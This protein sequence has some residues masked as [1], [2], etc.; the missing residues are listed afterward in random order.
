M[1]LY[2]PPALFALFVW[3]F[4]TGLIIYLDNLPRRTHRWS[5]AAAT[6]VLFGCLACL[7]ETSADPSLGGAY[8]GF[9]C[10]LLAWGWQEMSFFTGFVTGPVP[11]RCPPG[12]SGWDRF[13]RA[14]L[15]TAWHELAIALTAAVIVAATWGGA[16]QV[17][18]WTFMALWA[19]R[20]SAK[21]NVFLGVRNLSEEFVPEHL[22][23]IRSYLR[24]RPMNPLFPFAVTAGTLASA[25]MVNRAAAAPDAFA[26]T[27]DTFLAAMLILGVIEHWLLV[28]P[29]NF[30]A[31]W[32]WSLRAVKWR[33]RL[34]A[35]VLQ[36]LTPARACLPPRPAIPQHAGGD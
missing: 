29:V 24:Q 19:M 20:Q 2:G 3:W 23:F 27:G 33:P 7:R 21:F 31:L 18:T 1:S 9:T 10:G 16:N 14:V 36:G 8:A 34:P 13:R 30:A 4:S 15:A 26:A 12:C 32:S 35:P 17:G 25:V 22:A 28:L 5:M 6:A 11:E